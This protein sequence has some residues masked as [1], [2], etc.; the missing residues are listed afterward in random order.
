MLCG[1]DFSNKNYLRKEDVKT[2]IKR[3]VGAKNADAISEKDMDLLIKK[4][5][6]LTFQ[7]QF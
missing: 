6:K 5:K 2:L 1:L 4:V 3:L 7:A